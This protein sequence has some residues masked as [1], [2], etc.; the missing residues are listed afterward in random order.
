MG[1]ARRQTEGVASVNPFDESMTY[2]SFSLPL[3]PSENNLFAPSRGRHGKR[4]FRKKGHARDWQA[5]AVLEI[6]AAMRRQG[7]KRYSGPVQLLVRFTFATLA[8]DIRNRMKAL[9]DACTAAGVWH[10]DNRITHETISKSLG[11]PY[12]YVM[13]C[14]D[15][16]PDQS[17]VKPIKDADA[18]AEKPTRLKP[19]V[20]RYV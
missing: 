13:I 8:S 11:E 3:P 12:C 9:E 5:A 19:A 2:L 7:V 6:K 4:G 1:Q 18:R 15:E 16:D 14:E 10:D 20:T 17:L